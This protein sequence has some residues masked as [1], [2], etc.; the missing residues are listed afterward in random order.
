MNVIDDDNFPEARIPDREFSKE[1]GGDSPPQ[2]P[3]RDA[4]R[5]LEELL[6]EKR[7]REQIQ[8]YLSEDTDG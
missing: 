7:L 6:E 5:R 3:R 4:R 2:P 8:D 1:E